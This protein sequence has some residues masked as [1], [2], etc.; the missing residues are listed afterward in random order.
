MKTK[1]LHNKSRKFLPAKESNNA[2]NHSTLADHAESST[3]PINNAHATSPTRSAPDHSPS[4]SLYHSNQSRSPSPDH[5]QS[6]YISLL[7]FAA[8]LG[9][10]VNPN[11]TPGNRAPMPPSTARA[12]SNGHHQ[13]QYNPA[14]HPPPV[15]AMSHK[16][17]TGLAAM[18]T[19]QSRQAPHFE[20]KSDEILSEFLREYEDLADGNGLSE[21]LTVETVLHYVPHSLCNLWMNL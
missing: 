7:L 20:G 13:A 2:P 3:Q 6:P 15:S 16:Q 21:K 18:P 19:G 12:V 17:P 5:P 11:R 4:C 9:N 14:F 8:T 1:Q 10:L